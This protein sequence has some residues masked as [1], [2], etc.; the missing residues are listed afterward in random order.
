M[1]AL[2]PGATGQFLQHLREELARRWGTPKAIVVI[3]P[4]SM[5][6]QRWVSVAPTHTAVHDF[7]GFSP[8]LYRCQYAP[9]GEPGLALRVLTRLREAGIAAQAADLDGLDHGMWTVLSHLYPRAEVP[10]VPMSMLPQDRPVD[11]LSLG[12]ALRGLRHE[13]VLVIGSGSITHNLHRVFAGGMDPNAKEDPA[14]AQFRSWVRQASEHGLWP[15]LMN[16]RSSAPQAQTMHP[17]D[18]HWLPFYFAMGAAC[19]QGQDWPT[20]ARRLHADVCFGELGMDCYAFGL[21]AHGLD[22]AAH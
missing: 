19:E 20:N 21:D 12:R 17:T 9:A 22:L 1:L 10:V 3:S 11:L 13:G 2:E 4:H 8:E 14:C 6:R 5:S 16:Y 15:E 7:S 18:E